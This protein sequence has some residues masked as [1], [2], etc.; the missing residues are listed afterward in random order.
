MSKT[1]TIFKFLLNTTP[2]QSLSIPLLIL[3]SWQ[4][5]WAVSYVRMGK[6]KKRLKKPFSLKPQLSQYLIILI[7]YSCLAHL[8]T[9]G[10]LKHLLSQIT[11]AL[12]FPL[13]IW[14]RSLPESSNPDTDY[15]K[16][17]ITVDYGY[18]AILMTF[19]LCLSNHCFILFP[20]LPLFSRW[21]C[22]EVAE[23]W[24]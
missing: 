15:N 3:V 6:T 23:M 19:F 9:N 8:F 24:F 13:H 14:H 17:L 18:Y 22:W 4:V 16:L 2:E 7:S 12:M 10:Y 5:D 20:V 11:F 21:F 1:K